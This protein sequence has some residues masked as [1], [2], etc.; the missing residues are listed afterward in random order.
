MGYVNE[1]H[2]LALLWSS[3]ALSRV[4]GLEWS[5]FGSEHGASRTAKPLA[6]KKDI[7][8]A[9]HLLRNRIRYKPYVSQ[10]DKVM[11]ANLAN[12]GLPL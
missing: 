8:K 1:W 10:N 12:P 3:G 11:T 4:N 2:W 9:E 6:K 5:P 7:L